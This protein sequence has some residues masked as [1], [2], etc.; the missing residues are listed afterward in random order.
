MHSKAVTQL[1]IEGSNPWLQPI[2][3]TALDADEII[4]SWLMVN[5]T[6]I[7]D[8]ECVNSS[9]V[10]HLCE[11]IA[12]PRVSGGD[13]QLSLKGFESSSAGSARS[14]TIRTLYMSNM[15]NA[16]V[17]QPPIGAAMETVSHATN[18]AAN[19]INSFLNSSHL[20]SP[21]SDWNYADGLLFSTAESPKS[22]S[23]S[24]ILYPSQHLYLASNM[25]H[26]IIGLRK[27]LGKLGWLVATTSL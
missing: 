13:G 9:L 21:I 16:P 14:I 7:L 15:S 22:V 8:I 17:D 2:W 23:E 5:Q 25:T 26:F 27:L 10:A 6:S 1:R 3:H 24:Y 20:T 4:L 19:H 11:Y 18:E 12:E